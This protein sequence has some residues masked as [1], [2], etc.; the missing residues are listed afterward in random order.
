MNYKL[1]ALV[2]I[3]SMLSNAQFAFGTETFNSNQNIFNNDSKKSE[4][5]ET[6]NIEDVSDEENKSEQEDDYQIKKN[7]FSNETDAFVQEYNKK[8]QSFWKKHQYI[9]NATIVAGVITATAAVAAGTFLA[10]T[11]LPHWINHRLL[12]YNKEINNMK[13]ELNGLTSVVAKL[14]EQ[15]QAIV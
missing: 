10:T 13:L 12:G 11:T 2:L 3:G 15:Q 4:N 1:L 5:L 14:S 7:P 8:E 9:T 6:F